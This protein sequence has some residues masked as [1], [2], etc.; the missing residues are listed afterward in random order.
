MI[1][2]KAPQ[3]PGDFLVKGSLKN[4]QQFGMFQGIVK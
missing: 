4:G 3:L 1:E 2:K